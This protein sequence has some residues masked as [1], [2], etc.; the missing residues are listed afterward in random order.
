MRTELALEFLSLDF[1]SSRANDVVATT[2][3]A[4]ALAL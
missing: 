3:D 4:K 2:E 1:K